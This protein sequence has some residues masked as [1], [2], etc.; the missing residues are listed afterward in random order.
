[1]SLLRRSS[2]RILLVIFLV[3]NSMAIP[4][5]ASTS[6]KLDESLMPNSPNSGIKCTACSS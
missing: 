1:M 2:P 5:K 3:I 6:E 4:I